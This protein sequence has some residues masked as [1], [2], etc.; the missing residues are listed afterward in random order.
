MV[1]PAASRNAAAQAVEVHGLGERRACAI[2]CVARSSRR[3]R[4]VRPD[5]AAL[6][7]RLRERA[8]RRRRFG[9]RLLHVVRRPE[10]TP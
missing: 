3:C 9:H 1:T 10:A 5:D 6:R 7:A 8:D 4:S 2:P